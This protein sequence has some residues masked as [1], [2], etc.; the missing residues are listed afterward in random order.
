[1]ADVHYRTNSLGIRLVLLQAGGFTQGSPRDEPG[2]EGGESPERRVVL[3]RAFWIGVHQV[4]QEQYAEAMGENPSRFSGARH[5]V[6][7]VSWD[8]A[9]AFCRRLSEGEGVDYRL[10]TEAE[11]EYACRA[12]SATAYCFGDDP[13]R[14]D[15]FAWHRANSGGRPHEV[16]LKLP[17]AWGLY[18]VHGNVWEW[19][20]DA[21]AGYDPGV[22]EDPMGPREG[23]LRIV[24]GGSWFD[25]P[26]PLR[27]ACRGRNLASNRADD[28]GF[29]VVC[30]EGQG[31][32]GPRD[33]ASGSR[34]RR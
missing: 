6:E 21:Y 22:R 7:M 14:L 28:H 31:S 4:T 16:G 10:P 17:S 1:M 32:A 3:T 27:S 8:D 9:A 24:R 2:H 23:K 13:A 29:R 12:G 25:Y 19:C 33:R 20:L 15:E 5:P 34:D 18:D 30:L 11:W 26:L